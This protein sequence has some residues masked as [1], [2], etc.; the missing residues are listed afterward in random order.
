ML[1]VKTDDIYGKNEVVNANDL[2]KHLVNIDSRFRRTSVEPPT[3]FQFVFAHPYKN[4]IKARVASVE[5]PMGFYNFSKAKK[6]TMF[7]LDA[8]DYTGV[9]HFLP[10]TIADGD[11]TPTTLLEAIQEQFTAIKDKYGLF[12]RITL[13]PTSRKVTIAHDGSAPP[14]CPPGPTH[15]PVTFGLTFVMV[16][17]E[18]RTYDFG[19]GYF[20]GFTDHF[21]GVESPFEVTGESLI[22]TTADNYLLLAI[23]DFYTVEHKTADTYIQCLAK[24]LIKRDSTHTILFDDGYTVLS[25]D[26]VFPRP[27]DLK[28]VRVRLL[29]AYGVPI[30]LHH[31]NLSISL[32]IVEVMNVQLYDSYRTYLWSEVEPRAI[33][34]TRGSAAPIAAPGRNFN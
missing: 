6:N 20:L 29:D 15:C 34:N 17:L 25:N 22:S 8:M 10:I 19:L 33:R 18:D 16:G 5:I 4:V 23:E 28:Q 13:N 12:F 26:I 11:Y 31:L 1:N 32:E 7:R 24:I 21:Y 9:Q 3:D 14:P 2:R 30:D 27:T